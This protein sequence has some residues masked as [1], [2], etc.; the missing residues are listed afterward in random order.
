ML[1]LIFTFIV[2]YLAFEDLPLAKLIL[3]NNLAMC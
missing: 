3:W 1:F 2:Y